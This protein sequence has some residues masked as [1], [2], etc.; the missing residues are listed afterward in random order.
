M[1]FL[2]FGLTATCLFVFRRRESRSGQSESPRGLARVPGHPWTT[3]F[4][5]LA[6]WAVVLNTIYTYPRNTVVG[7]AILFARIPMYFLWS[8]QKSKRSSQP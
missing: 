4:F 6:C 3:L 7:F 5:A 2:F 1:D 8:R